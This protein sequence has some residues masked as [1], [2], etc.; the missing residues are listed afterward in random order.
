MM[1]SEALSLLQEDANAVYAHTGTRVGSLRVHN[2]SERNTRILHSTLRSRVS[3]LLHQW[4]PLLELEAP[5][6]HRLQHYRLHLPRRF[7][8][9]QERLERPI[10]LVS[11]AIA[12]LL[13]L[14]V[15]YLPRE[16][17]ELT[18]HVLYVSHRLVIHL[19]TP[20]C[21]IPLPLLV[22]RLHHVAVDQH[23]EY[24]PC[25]LVRRSTLT[26]VPKMLNQLQI[27]ISSRDEVLVVEDIVRVVSAH[28]NARRE[29]MRTESLSRVRFHALHRLQIEVLRRRLHHRF[30]H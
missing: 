13:L 17:V 30:L 26:I 27:V 18:L 5:S 8:L 9:I 11:S 19:P 16:C 20:H 6:H 23:S 21:R 14:V 29:A 25:A 10:T 12:I 4:L 2:I 22:A 15:E 3:S 7:V 24:E 28:K 1:H